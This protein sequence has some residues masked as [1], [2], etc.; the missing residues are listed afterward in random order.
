M[1]SPLGVSKAQ[2]VQ[3]QTHTSCTDSYEMWNMDVGWTHT[4]VAR[5]GLQLRLD[6]TQ[7]T[8]DKREGLHNF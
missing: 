5:S 8:S 4:F 7:N 6:Y 2:T 3:L 1:H